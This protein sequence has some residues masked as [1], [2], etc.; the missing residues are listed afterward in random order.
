MIDFACKGVFGTLATAVAAVTVGPVASA[1]F[2]V[3][4]ASSVGFD[5]QTAKTTYGQ[6]DI[7]SVPVTG[8]NF[9]DIGT[10]NGGASPAVPFQAT[11]VQNVIG[12][13]PTG[14]GNIYSPSTI[15]DFDV[16]LPAAV[17]ALPGD[18]NTRVVVQFGTLGTEIDYGSLELTDG[19]TTLTPI[20]EG[21]LSYNV[22]LVTTPGGTFPSVTAE[23]LAVFDFVGAPSEL[24][25][26]LTASGVNLSLD[27]VRVD[28][29]S[30]ATPLGS[31]DVP[32]FAIPEPATA[33]VLMVGVVL[34][35]RARRR[36]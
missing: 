33:G 23:Y 9:A 27:T 18:V 1:T 5:A 24:T 26:S 22:S 25:L 20:E 7:F 12:A 29:F 28:T 6:W 35:S 11:L 4:T 3:P 31:P 13:I 10:Y 34:L 19:S 30:S 17:D 15:A 14:S 21:Y 2:I 8:P 36:R 16:V 32:V